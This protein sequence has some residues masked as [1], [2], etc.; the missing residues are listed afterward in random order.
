MMAFNAD[1]GEP[2][3]GRFLLERNLLE[4]RVV[5]NVSVKPYRDVANLA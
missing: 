2:L 5:W 1:G 3:A 4:G